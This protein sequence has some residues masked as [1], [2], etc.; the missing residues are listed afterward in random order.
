MAAVAA[1]HHRCSLGRALTRYFAIQKHAA[2][3][4]LSA[5]QRHPAK[6]H[7]LTFQEYG[8]S[9]LFTP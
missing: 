8:L 5:S 9:L 2:N 6:S 1:S 3:V 4:P 7:V